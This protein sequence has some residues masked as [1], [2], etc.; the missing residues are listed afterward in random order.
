MLGE[1]IARL[2]DEAIA[3]ETLLS[4]D[5]LPLVARIGEASARAGLPPGAYAAAAVRSFVAGASDEDW[6]SLIGLMARDRDPSAAFLRRALA[7]GLAGA[8]SPSAPTAAG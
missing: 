5:D 3:A 6:L 1:V 8:A 7:Q 4:L 2:E